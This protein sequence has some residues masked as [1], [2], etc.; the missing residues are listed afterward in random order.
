MDAHTQSDHR[1]ARL[2]LVL[3]VLALC[4]GAAEPPRDAAERDAQT[5]ISS[6]GRGSIA[7]TR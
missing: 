2:A 7:S 5:A 1:R 3:L 4:E 6:P